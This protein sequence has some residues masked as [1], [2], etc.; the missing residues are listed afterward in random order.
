LT[1]VFHS[2]SNA[3]W[4]ALHEALLAAGF[5]LAD[6]RTL[7]KKIETHTQRTSAGAV[8]KDLVITAVRPRRAAA[9]RAARALAEGSV[10]AAWR[11]VRRRLGRLP[12]GDDERQGFLL[13]DRMVAFHL[14]RG[15]T[16]PLG[17]PA[18]YAGL[19][20]RFRER[21]RRC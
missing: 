7:D 14:R 11:F 18:F 21:G 6:V 5:T 12:L 1:L 8:Q 3:V 2:S 20:A 19:Q 16:V 10:E 9:S 4:N 13:Y 15:R 17:A